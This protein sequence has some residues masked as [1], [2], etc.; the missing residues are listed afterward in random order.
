MH[1]FQL[2]RF[3]GPQRDYFIGFDTVREYVDTIDKNAIL[4]IPFD[5]QTFQTLS[6]KNYVV[7]LDITLINDTALL[8]RVKGNYS[9]LYITNKGAIKFSEQEHISNV[10]ILT[11]RTDSIYAKLKVLLNR[12]SNAYYYVYKLKEVD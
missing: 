3:V 1:A 12:E 4:V 2:N 11:P 7:I 8:K 5:S 10:T 9:Q 6:S